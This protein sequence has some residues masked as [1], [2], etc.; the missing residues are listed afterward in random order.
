MCKLWQLKTVVI[1]Y[2]WVQNDERTTVI[3][4]LML[5]NKV[6]VSFWVSLFYFLTYSIVSGGSSVGAREPPGVI[7]ETY[8]FFIVRK[9]K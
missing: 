5:R 4:R 1:L 2:C 7:G 6:T 8:N 3:Q 9:K